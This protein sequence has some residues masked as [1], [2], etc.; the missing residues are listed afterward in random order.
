MNEEKKGMSFLKYTTSGLV[1]RNLLIPFYWKYINPSKVLKYHAHLRKIQWNSLEE[2][3]KIQ[4]K[5]LFK[6]I[7]YVS[8]NIPYY[9]KLIRNYGIQFSEETIFDD[10]RKFPLLTKD[11]IR[12]S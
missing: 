8:R 12:E 11:I 10:L 5:K 7:E 2:N 9:Q 4:R 1:R 3:G 6:L